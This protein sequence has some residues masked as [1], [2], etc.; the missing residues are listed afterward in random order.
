MTGGLPNRLTDAAARRGTRPRGRV[1]A[2][3]R[4]VPGPR[5]GRGRIR[6]RARLGAI[7]GSRGRTLRIG[8][9]RSPS[10]RRI[11]R[12]GRRLL[13]GDV[14]R[15]D[16][17]DTHTRRSTGDRRRIRLLRLPR[18]HLLRRRPRARRIRLLRLPRRHTLRRAPAAPRQPATDPPSSPAPAAPRPTH[19]PDES[20]AAGTDPPSSPAPAAPRP[21][22]CSDESFG[23]LRRIAF[24]ACPGGTPSDPRSGD[25]SPFAAGAASADGRSAER[26]S[27]A[28][29]LHPR[30]ARVGV[31]VADPRPCSG[32]SP[33]PTSRVPRSPCPTRRR[34]P[35][36]GRTNR[37]R[38]RTGRTSSSRSFPCPWRTRHRSRH[39]IPARTVSGRRRRGLAGRSVA[40]GR[41]WAASGARRR[42]HI[43]R[44]QQQRGDREGGEAHE[45]PACAIAAVPEGKRC[46]GRTHCGVELLAGTELVRSRPR[47]PTLRSSTAA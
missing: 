40:V 29:P 18:R 44:A 33:C 32:R 13:R 17:T 19:A 1:D 38:R 30:R 21:T 46:F 43:R 26:E 22:H 16:P 20:S 28:G 9:R 25:P 37:S 31:P 5:L 7:T 2:G 47:P 14:A 11:H 27:P 35:A 3:R 36:C 15:R 6:G 12:G 42:A 39:R 41:R 45:G 8:G 34:S 23:G 4:G 10:T 24:F